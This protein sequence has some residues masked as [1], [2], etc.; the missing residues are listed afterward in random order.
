MK[1]QGDE[2]L[3]AKVQIRS[4]EKDLESMKALKTVV[5]TAINNMSVA[6]G[7]T[8]ND[9]LA[10]ESAS[11][12]VA[13]HETMLAKTVETFKTGGLSDAAAES[14]TPAVAESRFD[15]AKS[16]AASFSQKTK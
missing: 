8:A 6:F 1:E 13:L 7:G 5:A 2:L 15:R 14:E 11:A 16:Q 3:E 9:K 4:L 12:L 10:E